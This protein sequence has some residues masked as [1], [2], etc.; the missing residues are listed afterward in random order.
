MSDPNFDDNSPV[1]RGRRLGKVRQMAGINISNLAMQIGYSRQ[2]VSYW[3]NGVK[4]GLSHEGAMKIVEVVNKLGVHCEIDWLFYGKGE[5]PQWLVREKTDVVYAKDA[6]TVNQEVELFTQLHPHTVV[7]QVPHQ[8]MRP[9]YEPHD[10]IGGCWQPIKPHL[11]GKPCIM[12]I[13]DT[14]QVRMLKTGDSAGKFHLSFMSYL[15]D[16]A[17]PFE[18]KNISLTQVAPVVRVWR[19]EIF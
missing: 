5:M 8:F 6:K 18:L 11:L 2:A 10:W 17:Q 3:E 9:L 12:K 7:M 19:P 14:L 13:A 4:T 15:V 16:A 1:A